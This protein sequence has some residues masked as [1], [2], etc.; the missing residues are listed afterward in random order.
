MKVNGRERA[1]Q[2]R[3]SWSWHCLGVSSASG[4]FC[5]TPGQAA[6]S[7]NY[8]GGWPLSCYGRYG[9]KSHAHTWNQTPTPP[10]P[11]LQSST[12]CCKVRRM[13]LSLEYT[14]WSL[15]KTVEVH[16]QI[17]PHLKHFI[18]DTVEQKSCFILIS[19]MFPLSVFSKS[20]SK[21]GVLTT[22]CQISTHTDTGQSSHRPVLRAI[23]EHL[24]PMLMKYELVWR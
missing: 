17:N 20:K 15:Q 9:E 10:S 1:Q 23:F 16:A 22:L 13:K 21:S 8:V 6:P 4:L 2:F 3:H 5:F 18:F 24:V 12:G 14:T 11:S 7:M 19:V